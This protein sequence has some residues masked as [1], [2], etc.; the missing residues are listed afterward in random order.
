M[1]E[2]V[3]DTETTGLNAAG[4]DRLVE[5]GCVEIFDGFPTGN[6]FHRYL[7]PERD[8]PAD[9]F[10]IH[11]LSIEFLKDKSKFADICADFVAFIGD[12]P[13]VAHN[14]A[15]DLGFVNAE[16]ERCKKPR[17]SHERL[18]DTL[19]LARRRWPGSGNKLDD[20]CR[21]FSI[22]LS[23]RTKHGALLDSELLAEVYIEITGKRQGAL[24]LT[25]A[26]LP[27]FA[28]SGPVTKR[29]TPLK[30][31]ITAE[32]LAAHRAFVDTLGEAAVWN[33]YLQEAA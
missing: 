24:L 29:P 10:A 16:L 32:E 33:D 31:L 14:A 2:I 3:F 7:N 27:S 25:D 22:D 11:G 13:L 19:S 5:I 23:K 20:L 12:A 8:M 18:V 15:F 17:I 1:R 28:P 9:A 26:N 4:G 6:T 30:S 21:R